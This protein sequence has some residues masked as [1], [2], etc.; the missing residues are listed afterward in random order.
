M[1]GALFVAVIGTGIVL[2][3]GVW[4]GLDFALSQETTVSKCDSS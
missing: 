1:S 2:G 3:I 4:C